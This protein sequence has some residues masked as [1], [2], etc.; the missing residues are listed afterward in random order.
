MPR[1]VPR[2]S[3]CIDIACEDRAQSTVEAAFLLPTF[4]TG[5]PVM[6]VV[7]L[8]SKAPD[9]EILREFDA[10]HSGNLE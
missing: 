4:L 5:L 9:E 7:S 6:I 2:T 1:R 3:L 10:V 8:L